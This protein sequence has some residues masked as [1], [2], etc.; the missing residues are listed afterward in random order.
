M[1]DSKFAS[2]VSLIR[3]ECLQWDFILAD[4]VVELADSPA[5]NDMRYVCSS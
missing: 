2:S 3:I 1:V 4:F 5:G